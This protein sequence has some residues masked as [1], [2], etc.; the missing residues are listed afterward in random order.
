[1]CT[2]IEVNTTIQGTEYPKPELLLVSFCSLFVIGT[3]ENKHPSYKVGKQNIMHVCLFMTCE[4]FF[5]KW[6]GRRGPK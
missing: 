6:I 1:M 3:F 4:P 5:F 2:D